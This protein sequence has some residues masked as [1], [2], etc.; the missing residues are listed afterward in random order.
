[1][2]CSSQSLIKKDAHHVLLLLALIYLAFIS[3]GLPDSSR[4]CLAFHVSRVMCPCFLWRSSLHDHC[5]RH[6]YL[7]PKHQSRVTRFGTGL[8]QQSV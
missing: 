5:V 4:L 8:S 6:R 1:M 2:A 7:K 3:L